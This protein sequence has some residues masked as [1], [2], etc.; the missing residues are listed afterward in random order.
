[1]LRKHKIE[2]IQEGLLDGDAEMKNENV[3]ADGGSEAQSGI[4]NFKEGEYI[5]KYCPELKNYPHNYIYQP[6]KASPEQQKKFGAVLGKDYPHPLVDHDTVRSR[7]LDR[8]SVAYKNQEQLRKKFSK[9]GDDTFEEE[10]V[11]EVEG[12][13]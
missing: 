7:N 11:E 2:D 9:E 5:K 8:M 1:M 12:E 13:E 4:F 3:H 10:K 6:W